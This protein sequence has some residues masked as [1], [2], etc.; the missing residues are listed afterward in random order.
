MFNERSFTKKNK[1]KQS[2]KKK[3]QEIILFLKL[4]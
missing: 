1:S 4:C 3:N 2:R